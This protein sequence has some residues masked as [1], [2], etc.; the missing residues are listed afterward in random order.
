VYGSTVIWDDNFFG[1][2]DTFAAEI[3]E[4]KRPIE[5]SISSR[6]SSQSNPDIDG[7]IVVWQDDRLGDWDIFGYNLTTGQEFLITDNAYDQIN[8]AISGNTLVFEDNRNGSWNIYAVILS[9]PEIAQCTSDLQGDAN[10]DCKVDLLDIA[11][12][13]SNWLK[14]NLE[15]AEY[16]W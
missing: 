12:I 7:H 9:G 11:I 3:Y 16:C 1:D 14:C 6:V 4:P 10:G 15:P 13:S 5:F 2:S 8:P